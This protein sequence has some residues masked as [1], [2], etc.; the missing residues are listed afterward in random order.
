MKHRPAQI[1]MPFILALIVLATAAPSLAVRLGDEDVIHTPAAPSH[2]TAAPAAALAANLDKQQP[3]EPRQITLAILDFG[4]GMHAPG[5]GRAVSDMLIGALADDPMIRI[6]ERAQL[7]EIME[8]QK[9]ANP[10]DMDG[11][12]IRAAREVGVQFVLTGKVSEFGI[13]ENGILI[14]GKGTVTQYKARATLDVR[15]ISVADA[16]VIK[17]WTTTGSETSYNLG[18]NILGIPNFSFSGRQFEESLLGKATRQA[19]DSAASFIRDDVRTP[20]IQENIAGMPLSGKVADVEGDDLILNIGT[21]AGMEM[22]WSVNIYRLEKQVKD[23]D[24][25]ELLMEKRSFVATAFV[26]SVEEKYSK[27][28]IL[29]TGPGAAVMVGDQVEIVKSNGNATP[30]QANP[31]D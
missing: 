17:T 30:F 16:G 8:E 29:Q 4:D 3:A 15:L 24:T 10:S 23:P 19:V 18:V 12:T 11:N 14:P 21:L 6:F 7:D 28:Q 31:D 25:G 27:A 13:N 22:G 5:I 2:S 26:Y 9:R 1:I 20:L